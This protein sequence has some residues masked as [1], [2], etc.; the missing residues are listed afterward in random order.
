[1]RM[2]FLLALGAVLSG[3]ARSEA[4][5]VVFTHGPTIRHIAEL[6]AAQQDAARRLI[7]PDFAP[8]RRVQPDQNNVGMANPALGF[9]YDYIGAFWIEVWTWNGTYCLYEGRRARPIPPAQAA[10]LLGV[11]VDELPKPFA[12][13]F[14]PGLL[15]IGG[16]ILLS[17]AGRLLRQRRQQ[18]LETAQGDPRYQQA[19]QLYQQ[20][21]QT[22]D[23]FE[24]AVVYLEREGIPRGE[25]M[26]TL[27]ALLAPPPGEAT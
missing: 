13:R 8:L 5:L 22:E 24:E 16:L 1:M 12:Y 19:L 11:S 17:T 27:R 25:A 6:N 21:R 9:R 18:R 26:K 14:P 15:A 2:T 7:P 3:P 23:A 20:G 4:G 10:E